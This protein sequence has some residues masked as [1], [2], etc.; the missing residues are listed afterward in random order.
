MTLGYYVL[1]SLA[2]PV[3]L[4]LEH[5]VA[6]RRG[7]RVYSFATTVNSLSHHLAEMALTVALTLDVF[8]GYSWL[9]AR[10]AV[11]APSPAS[12]LTWAL[13]FLAV[14]ALY[15][16][17]HRA[18]HRVGLLWALHAVHHQAPEYNLSVGLRGPWLSALQIAPFMVPLALVGFPTSVLFPVYAAHTLYKLFVHTDLVG[19][20]GPLDRVLVSPAQHRV[21]HA[22][23]PEYRGANY[24]GVLAIWDRL[25]GTAKA[26]TVAPSFAPVGE[27]ASWNPLHNNVAPWVELAR[28]AARA[29]GLSGALRALFGVPS[30]SGA[31]AGAVREGGGG[32]GGGGALALVRL[33]EAAAAP[34]PVRPAVATGLS[35]VA[36]ATLAFLGYGSALGL[37]ER[38]AAAASIVACLVVLNGALFGWSGSIGTSTSRA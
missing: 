36:A 19:G 13:C 31:A 14:D 5:A 8:A 34:R 20:F 6:V 22:T 37:A 33:S 21:H 7:R 32:G 26:E 17:G 2:A 24:G 27:G 1:A 12:W 35:L 30:D 11:L 18:C 10:V 29:P 3:A 38:A 23:N 4:G 15:Y 25:F 28:R 16:L 9:V